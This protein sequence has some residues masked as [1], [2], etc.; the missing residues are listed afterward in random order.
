MRYFTTCGR[1][2]ELIAA[3]ELRTDFGAADIE[4]RDGKVFFTFNGNSVT[5]LQKLK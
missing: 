1:G 5:E 3:E 4:I 2:L